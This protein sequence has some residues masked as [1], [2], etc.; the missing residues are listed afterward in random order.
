MLYCILKVMLP[1]VIISNQS[2][3]FSNLVAIVGLNIIIKG[4][5]FLKTCSAD[6]TS[7]SML[8]KQHNFSGDWNLDVFWV[9]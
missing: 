7:S 2:I 9:Y 8:D 3:S 5:W 1:N 4:G 6:C